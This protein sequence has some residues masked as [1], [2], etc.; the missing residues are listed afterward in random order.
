MLSTF[1]YT[2][3]YI[4]FCVKNLIENHYSY[5]LFMWKYMLWCDRCFAEV[6]KGVSW[7]ERLNHFMDKFFGQLFHSWTSGHLMGHPLLLYFV[8]FGI[9][10]RSRLLEEHFLRH[11]YTRI[12][13]IWWILL[14]PN[15]KRKTLLLFREFSN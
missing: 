8:W 12:T 5:I 7:R 6:Q 11:S 1:T 10:P 15:F 13:L 2:Y 9:M 4:S 3:M 14:C